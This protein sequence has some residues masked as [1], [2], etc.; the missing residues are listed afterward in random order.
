MKMLFKCFWRNGKGS[1]GS[2][3]CCGFIRAESLE[4]AE[5]IMRRSLQEGCELVETIPAQE[6]WITP[7]SLTVNF[8]NMTEYALFG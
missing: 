2:H 8:A 7:Q 5:K 4:D 1:A 3:Q 6:H